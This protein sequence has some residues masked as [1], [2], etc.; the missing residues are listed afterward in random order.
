MQVSNVAHPQI[1]VSLA[2]SGY[3]DCCNMAQSSAMIELRLDLMPLELEQIEQLLHYPALTVATC[4]EGKFGKLERLRR[5]QFAIRHGATYVDI[6]VEAD[7]IYRKT[8]VEFANKHG[9]K[10]I[11][12]Y[13]NFEQTPSLPEMRKII[14]DCRSM[15]ADVVKL[16]TTARS[17]HD[18]ARVLSLYEGESSL[19]AFAMGDAGKITRVACLYLGAPFTYASPAAGLEAAPGQITADDMNL[20]IQKF[21]SKELGGKV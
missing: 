3:A 15:N 16:V 10:V 9:C 5:L 17:T 12:S 4:R 7:E 2:A 20:I 13:H 14:A 18:S 21:S 11:I 6:E 19:V 1:C 8:L